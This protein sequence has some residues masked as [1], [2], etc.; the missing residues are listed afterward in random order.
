ML[1]PIL[2]DFLLHVID[3]LAKMFDQQPEMSHLLCLSLER[4]L[5]GLGLA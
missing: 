3:E 1:Y 4:L 5:L 2:L